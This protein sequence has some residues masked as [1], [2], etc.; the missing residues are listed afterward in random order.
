MANLDVK[1][2]EKYDLFINGNLQKASNDYFE[3]L[4]PA[5]GNVLTKMGRASSDDVDKAVRAAR[6]AFSEWSHTSI[7]ERSQYLHK[8]A[9]A[10]EE[11]KE[12]LSKIDCLDTGRPIAEFE[13]NYGDYNIAIAQFRYFASA[14]LNFEGMSRPLNDGQ[15][16]VQREP[17]GVCGQI[18]PWNVPMVILSY[19][20]A[21]AIAAGNTVVL[22]PAED[23]SISTM[24]FAKLLQDILPAGVVNFVTGFGDEAGQAILD[25]PDIDK[26]AF[27]GSTGVGRKVGKTA[28][29]KL[30]PATL[31]L[32]GK[33]PHIVFPDV[34]DIE[35]AV[36]TV[37]FGFY[38]YNGQGCLNGT[39]I[40]QVKSEPFRNLILSHFVSTHFDPS[41]CFLHSVRRP[42]HV[43]DMRFMCKTIG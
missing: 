20:V 18:I 9:D 33:S 15:L 1:L 8:V 37:A 34:D 24:E 7:E 42:Y 43:Y 16:V 27:T 29:E 36:E 3:V 35:R 11:N 12:R 2:D 25:H 13:S 10:L 4:N 41:F 19:K 31:E 30:I 22:K 17:F 5:N 32:G 28:G 6:E 21:P 23:A 26:L 14:I 40:S 39:C 38:F